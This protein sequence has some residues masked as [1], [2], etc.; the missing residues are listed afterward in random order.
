MPASA[1]VVASKNTFS[2][3]GGGGGGLVDG[4]NVRITGS[5]F[6]TNANIVQG[7]FGGIN[8]PLETA[9]NGLNI[10]SGLSL[11]SSWAYPGGDAQFAVTSRTL[12]GS[13]SILNRYGYNVATGGTYGGSPTASIYGL[14]FD[15]GATWQRA[16]T[17]VS[18]YQTGF[19]N[20]QI[21]FQRFCGRLTDASGS[22][23]VGG[24][25]DDCLPNV[26]L[27]CFNGG[28]GSSA[29]TTDNAPSNGNA[30]TSE[31][32][33][34]F[35]VSPS[36]I[37]NGWV[38]QVYDFTPGTLATANGSIAWRFF[39]ATNIASVVGSGSSTS[40]RFWNGSDTAYR[41]WLMQMY[42]GNTAQV[43]GAQVNID[44]DPYG[45][46]NTASN[47]FPKFIYLGDASTYAACTKLVAGQVFSSWSDTQID[48]TINKG[49]H[50]S[51]SSV[52]AYVMSG[53]N[54][55]INASGIVPS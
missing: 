49:Q 42:M 41:W 5:G 48:F 23:S 1:T 19:T 46:F 47:A 38:Q 14:R 3:G 53:I 24:L 15:P 21:K 18:S 50:T 12:N 36:W 35:A 33:I 30:G 16:V 26:L 54:T 25:T 22:S 11:G 55:P 2:T 28:I 9:T 8:S 51:L 13:R 6:G 10:V 29:Q 34:D 52:W 44:R 27:N 4:T 37:N 17:I 20:G 45:L 40:K 32:N 43:D 31:P 39:N 7:F